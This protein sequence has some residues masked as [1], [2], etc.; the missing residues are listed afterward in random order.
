M[1]KTLPLNQAFIAKLGWKILT[2]SH[3]FWVNLVRKRYL[4]NQSF[5]TYKPKQSDSAIWRKIMMQRDIIRKGIRWKIGNGHS[6]LFWLD[7]W[8]T[9]SN[10]LDL[11]NHPTAQVDLSLRLSSFILP[12]GTWD[13]PKI[14]VVLPSH[15]LTKVKGI[16]LPTIPTED[17]PVWGPT[18]HGEFTV[19]SAT[20]LA[21]NIDPT[22]QCWP[23]KWIWKL[24]LPPKL[25][26]FLWQ[27]CHSSIGVRSVLHARQII[28]FA[29]CALCNSHDETLDHLFRS[30]PTIRQL[31]QLPALRTWLSFSLCQTTMLQS[32]QRLKQNKTHVVKLVY[33][34]W[35]IWKERNDIIFNQQSLNIHRILHKAQFLYTEWSTR[36]QLDHHVSTGTPYSST[37]LPPNQHPQHPSG[38]IHVRWSPPLAESHKLN[39]D[40]SVRHNSAA[41]G[42]IIRDS[43]GQLLTACAYNLGSAPVF[44]AEATGLQKGILLALQEGIS[45]LHIEGDNLL[46]I[47]S[48]LGLCS[49]PWQ[50]TPLI[51]DI[52]ALLRS[53]SS[54]TIKH[55]YREANQA[56]DWVA[57]V[58]HM[59]DSPFVIR[60]CSNS[61]LQTILVND[62][63]GPLLVQRVS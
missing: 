46:V 8:L 58:G 15:L 48:V 36:L 14:S 44:V 55:I 57:Y 9:H 31:W 42:I 3:N 47:N 18:S 6:I 52:R 33:L 16:P 21:H 17:T 40:G 2:D 30:C 37:S 60:S 51:H 5:F 38:V 12:N 1:H 13:L 24:D 26:I 27:I 4:K 28:P 35:S 63:L 25:L 29:T 61:A 59:L 62:I 43:A 39:F 19:K 23:F 32:L 11:L 22:H 56:A 34:M 53:F 20:W 7:N 49:I 45:T 10:L 54:W 41:A 50:I